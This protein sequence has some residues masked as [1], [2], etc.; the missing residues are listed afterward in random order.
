MHEL[1]HNLNMAHSGGATAGDPYGD[2]SCLMGDPLWEDDVGRMCYN[3]AK[4]FQ[5][6]GAGDGGR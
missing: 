5:I 3:A 1:G 2:H 6:A 4:N